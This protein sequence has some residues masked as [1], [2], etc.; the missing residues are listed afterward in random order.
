[1]EAAPTDATGPR[2]DSLGTRNQGRRPQST[3]PSA[4]DE[5]VKYQVIGHIEKRPQTPLANQRVRGSSLLPRTYLRGQRHEGER[6]ARTL[7]L[8]LLGLREAV[9]ASDWPQGRRLEFD[10]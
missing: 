7:L 5:V 3:T 9:L 8:R 2:R 4:P 6:R 1:M 10:R